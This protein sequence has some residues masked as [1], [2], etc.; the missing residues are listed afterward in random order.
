MEPGVDLEGMSRDLS[1]FEPDPDGWDVTAPSAGALASDDDLTIDPQWIVWP[2]SPSESSWA[3]T[4]L[5]IDWSAAA[6]QV[7]WRAS[8]G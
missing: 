7:G 4:S 6:R 8:V 2:D 3:V 1:E 5:A